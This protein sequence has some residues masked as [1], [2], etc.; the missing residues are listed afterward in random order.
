MRISRIYIGLV[1]GCWSLSGRADGGPTHTLA[2]FKGSVLACVVVAAE[3]VKNKRIELAQYNVT[4][5]EDSE[6]VTLMLAPLDAKPG[7]RG[8]LGSRPSFEVQLRKVGCTVVKSHY[9][10]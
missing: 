8:S 5:A 6:L 1:C 4:V 2:N 9:V 10:R 3:E 7:V